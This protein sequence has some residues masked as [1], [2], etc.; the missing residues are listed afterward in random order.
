MHFCILLQ[1]DS[2]KN[3]TLRIGVG[4]CVYRW[5]PP[6]LRCALACLECARFQKGSMTR[7]SIGASRP[8]QPKPGAPRK[9]ALL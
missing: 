7:L 9:T 5:R 4:C 6:C 8:G 2:L 1:N 3:Q